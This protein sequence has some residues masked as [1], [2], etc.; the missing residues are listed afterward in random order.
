VF[1]GKLSWGAV[2]RLRED[3]GSKQGTFTPAAE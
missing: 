3:H 1:I 2:S